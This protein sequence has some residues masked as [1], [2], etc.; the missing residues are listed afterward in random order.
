MTTTSP[1]ILITGA[2]GGGKS[3]LLDELALRGHRT[4]PEPGRRIVKDQLANGEV[5]LPWNDMAA[6]A[7]RVLEMTKDDLESLA[8]G[9]GPIFFDRG[10]VDAAVA[11]HH[12]TG[13]PLAD[14]LGDAPAYDALVFVAPPW[15]EIYEQDEE[16]R[17][18]LEDATAE[19]HRI[20]TALDRLGYL[21]CKQKK[22]TVKD[23]ADFVLDR[24]T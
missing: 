6:F 2:S 9:D 5:D 18:G 16:R 13:R 24:L 14:S 21:Q 1:L 19:Y 10:S 20:C 3:S 23:R 8:D 11:L 22:T 12:S 17:H 7:S 15:P 4:V